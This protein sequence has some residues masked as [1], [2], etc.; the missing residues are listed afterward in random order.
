MLLH[1]CVFLFTRTG[2]HSQ[3]ASQVT[4]LGG[5]LHR[6][7]FR[8]TGLPTGGGG[9]VDP[10]RYMGYYWDTV[11]KRVVRILLECILVY[12]EFIS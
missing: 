11:N 12:S 9:W 10:L 2:V 1:L 3:H 8:L 7:G 6:G 4:W 5:G